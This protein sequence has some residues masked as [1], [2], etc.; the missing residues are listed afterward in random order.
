[1]SE[2]SVARIVAKTGLTAEEAMRRLEEQ[3]PQRRLYQPDEVAYLVV[4]LA[5]PRAGGVNG[6]SI[7]LDGG[8]V[9]A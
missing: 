2:E 1:M 5:D 3:S 4:C 7:V 9:Q 6:Q 8:S